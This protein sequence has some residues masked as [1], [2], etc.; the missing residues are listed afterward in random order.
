MAKLTFLGATGEVTGSR[1]LIEPDNSTLLLECGLLQGGHNA[2]ER[3]RTPLSDLARRV[4]AVV[5]S[6]AHLDHCGLLP[7]LIRAGYRG[8]IHC[9]PATAELLEIM[10]RDAAFVMER[11][12]E[13]ENAWRE[14][15]RKSPL[16]PLFDLDDV[17][18]TLD[19]CEPLAYGEPR[20]ITSDATIVFRDAGH[21]LGSAIVEFN[22]QSAGRRRRLVFSGDL[23]NPTSALM[24]APQRVHNADAVLLESTYGDR[25]HRPLDETIEELA[26]ILETA[27]DDGGN[28]L[29][30][31]F[32][33]GRTQALLYHLALLYYDNRLP[34]QRIFLDAPM[35]IEVSELY[36]RLYRQLNE[37]DLRTLR[38]AAS[39][40]YTQWLPPLRITRTP[41]ESMQINRLSGGAIIIAG[42]GMCEGGRIL[43]HLRYNVGRR[44]C[45]LI[46]SGF[47]AS[48]TRGRQLVDGAD[49]ITLFGEALPVRATVHTLGG[50]SAHAGQ[51]ELVGW[52]AAF[53]DRPVFYLVHGERAK[54]EALQSA[55]EEQIDADVRIPRMGDS[56]EI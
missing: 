18:A 2:D 23:G 46:I 34:Q 19:R 17:I 27:S 29:I 47:Q 25:D 44:N 40:D 33:V 21:I 39:D 9:T 52:A 10:L 42:S 16:E 48:G 53:E 6:H 20:R 11:E 54:Q 28:V 30:P 32:A 14:K 7:R 24:N 49:E 22:L 4:D 5:L 3:N 31:A 56:V 36:A 1:Y 51:S 43:H 15:R 12:L 8:P 13:A 37:S 38:E 26:G 35:G 50:L 41:E 45:H 55:L